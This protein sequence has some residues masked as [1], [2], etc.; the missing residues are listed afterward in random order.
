MAKVHTIHGS[1]ATA[2]YQSVWTSLTMKDMQVYASDPKAEALVAQLG[3]DGAVAR[4]PGDAVTIA[5]CNI[6]GNKAS[7]LTKVTYTDAVTLTAQGA[8]THHL[9]I[10]YLFDSASDPSLIHY[11]YRKDFYQNYMRVYAPANAELVSYS[12][13]NGGET[14]INH[15]D[16]PGRQMWGG[17]VNLADGVSYSL[18]FT[19]TVPAAATRDAQGHWNYAL[20]YQRQSGSDQRLNLT[21]TA[22]GAQHP[23]VTFNGAITKDLTFSLSYL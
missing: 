8:A 21:I 3:I 15:S 23:G 18:H 14:Q 19:W 20:D 5:D 10:T 13:F 7:E 1:Q 16:L 4:G 22:P 6:T 12:G 9:T 17:L 11:L 2:V